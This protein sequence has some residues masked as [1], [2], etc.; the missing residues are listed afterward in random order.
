MIINAVSSEEIKL[1]ADEV[2]TSIAVKPEAARVRFIIHAPTALPLA[3]R[4]TSDSVRQ[5][6]EAVV[7][8]AVDSLGRAG[9]VVGAYIF[10]SRATLSVY[11]Y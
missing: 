3:L 6:I 8:T 4:A 5:A 9:G 2:C 1:I 10:A 7:M 11:V